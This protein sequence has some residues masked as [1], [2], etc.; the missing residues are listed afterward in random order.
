MPTLISIVIQNSC[1]PFCRPLA[2]Y[3]FDSPSAVTQ[4]DSLILSLSDASPHSAPL[5]LAWASSLQLLQAVPTSG[6][7][8][9]L[10]DVPPE[11]AEYHIQ[12]AEEGGAFEQMLAMLG[13]E[14]FSVS[15]PQVTAYKVGYTLFRSLIL[16]FE[17]QSQ[18]NMLS[19]S[20]LMRF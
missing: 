2:G 6:G 14:E 11:G 15:E 13:K 10:A 4:F 16:R 18:P 20:L 1:S 17:L 3:P 19:S 8:D 5:S 12:R 7:S 9:L